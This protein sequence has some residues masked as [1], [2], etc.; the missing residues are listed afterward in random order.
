MVRKI[1]KLPSRLDNPTKNM[2]GLG[3]DWHGIGMGLAKGLNY[4]DTWAS[5]DVFKDFKT[6]A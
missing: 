3:W 4:L 1:G 2:M 5:V 6:G